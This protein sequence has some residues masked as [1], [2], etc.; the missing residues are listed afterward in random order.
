MTIKSDGKYQVYV[1]GKKID[2]KDFQLPQQIH[3]QNLKLISDV[4]NKSGICQGLNDDYCTRYMK[5]HKG[6]I[7]HKGKLSAYLD[8]TLE[9][10]ALQNGYPH[11]STVR[12]VNCFLLVKDSDICKNCIGYKRH[13][14]MW[15]MS[16]LH[17]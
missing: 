14:C 7:R 9:G 11:G 10:G 1:L 5:R 6:E 3:V 15:D 17:L 16:I 4:L 12:V 13:L 2:L 8:S